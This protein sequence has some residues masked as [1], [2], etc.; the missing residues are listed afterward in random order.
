M[1]A[2]GA[3]KTS[4]VSQKIFYAAIADTVA[5]RFVDP[6]PF[7]S[8]RGQSITVPRISNMTE[9]TDYSLSENDRIPEK[10]H[11][12]TGK[13]VT[14]SEFGAAVPWTRFAE[15]LSVFDLRSTIQRK[16]KQDMTLMLDSRA[17]RAFKLAQVKYV[18]TGAASYST[19]TNGT[20]P[21]SALANINVY[22]L[23]AIRDLL[24]DTYKAP[25]RDGNYIGI[26]RTLGIRGI[27]NDADWE[28]WHQYTD[29]QAKYNHEVGTIESI[30]LIEENHGGSSVS[31]VGLN[32]GLGTGAVLGEGVVFGEEATVLVES[33]TPTIVPGQ[34]DD[35]GR[36][37]SIAWYGQFEID[38]VWDTA[39][40]GEVRIVHVTS[41]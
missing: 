38:I 2:T 23:G 4:E 11:T 33:L 28:L 26:F 17:L 1:P 18:P 20:A 31:G 37:K 8:G 22:H 12:V 27:M 7:G 30:R 13:V 19:S 36:I 25:M 6:M 3:L 35:Y 15:D 34:P 5:M 24:Y 21:T 16:L 14:V 9:S 39:N 40:A 29:P 41:T 10:S 32:T